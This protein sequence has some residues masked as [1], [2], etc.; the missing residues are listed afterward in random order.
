MTTTPRGSVPNV[1]S[2]ELRAHAETAREGV[3]T[4]WA[5]NGVEPTLK[6]LQ[7]GQVRTDRGTLGGLGRRCFLGFGA[8]RHELS[9]P[10]P[11][12]FRL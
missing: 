7:R 1:R 6:A 10:R 11:Q 8:F 9:V 2:D 12:G 4:G 3:G 5:V